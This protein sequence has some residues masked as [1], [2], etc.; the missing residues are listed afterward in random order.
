VSKTACT[1]GI[2]ARTRRQASQFRRSSNRNSQ[3]AW[4]WVPSPAAALASHVRAAATAAA[5]AAASSAAA[6]RP[7][8]VACAPQDEERKM[9]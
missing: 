6:E 1:R 7:H 9:S 2:P 8:A 3:V 5:A 4:R